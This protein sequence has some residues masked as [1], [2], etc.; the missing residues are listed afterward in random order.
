M[1]VICDADG[2]DDLA[3]IMGGERTGVSETTTRMFLEIAVF[4]PTN[5]ASTGRQLNIHS[6]ARYRFERG[7][8]ATSP[9]QM[10]GYIARF[11]QSICGGRYSQLVVS[12]SADIQPKTV[13]FS[14]ARTKSLT[15]I[16][17]SEDR[18]KQILTALGF[19]VDFSQSKTWKVTIP[20]WRNDIDG[21]AD[22]VEEV[23]RIHGY[24][25]L[26]M[27]ALPRDSYIARPAFS[28]VQLR[29]V[30]LRRLLAGRSLIEAVTFFFPAP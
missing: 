18:Q 8:D 6:D 7:L 19:H 28:P 24:E 5:V 17:C 12:G 4:D 9:V 25:N 3:G 10:A 2:P 29:P 13:A 15:G 26:E 23:I 30:L 20:S 11:V 14:P 16:A 27:T 21:P 1:L 22:L